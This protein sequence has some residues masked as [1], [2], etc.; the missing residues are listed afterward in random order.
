V[1]RRLLVNTYE[2]ENNA[3]MGHKKLD[4]GDEQKRERE[5]ERERERVRVR[6]RERE[7]KRERERDANAESVGTI[8]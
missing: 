4:S 5:R 3:R 6:E 7:R 8:T 2:E 1:S